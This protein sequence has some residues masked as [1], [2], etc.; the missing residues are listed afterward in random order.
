[1]LDRGEGKIVAAAPICRV[2]EPD[3]L[4]YI[5]GESGFAALPALYEGAFSSL[6]LA[7]PGARRV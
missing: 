4:G 5:P 2:E 3:A 7:A 6:D 1:V